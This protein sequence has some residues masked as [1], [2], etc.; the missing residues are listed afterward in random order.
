[1]RRVLPTKN[2]MTPIAEVETAIKC[3]EAVEWSS[4]GYPLAG[5]DAGEPADAGWVKFGLRP[6]KLGW[7]TLEFLAWVCTDMAQAGERLRFFPTAP[8]PY[9][10]TPGECLSFVLECYPKDGDQDQRFRKVA[11]FITWCHKERWAE[12]RGRLKA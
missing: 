7:R 3:F 1:M 12:C 6:S 2:G 11:E 5:G 8:P 10:N 9:L 4:S